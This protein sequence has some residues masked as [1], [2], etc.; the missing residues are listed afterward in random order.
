MGGAMSRYILPFQPL[1]VPIVLFVF[2]RLYQGKYRRPYT[3]WIIT[4]FVLLMAVL[5]YY[6]KF[7]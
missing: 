3:V 2:Y 1:M 7:R 4:L 6:L 5:I